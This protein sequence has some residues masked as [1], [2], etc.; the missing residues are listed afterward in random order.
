MILPFLIELN[1]KLYYNRRRPSFIILPSYPSPPPPSFTLPLSSCHHT[2]HRHHRHFYYRRHPFVLLPTSN[3]GLLHYTL[4]TLYV[5]CFLTFILK[6]P[7]ISNN[8][9][10]FYFS[11]TSTYLKNETRNHR[12]ISTI[13]PKSEYQNAEIIKRSASRSIQSGIRLSAIF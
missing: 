2:L 8:F 6:Q 10:H 5:Y 13:I 4:D 9:F 3:F 11:K 12:C 1:P 7:K